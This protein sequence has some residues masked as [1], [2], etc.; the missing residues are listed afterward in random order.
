MAERPQPMSLRGTETILV[1]EDDSALRIVTCR[2]LARMGYTVI[3]A[4]DADAARNVA[5]AA[6]APIHLLLSDIVIPGTNGPE[7]AKELAQTH[8]DLKVL[9]MSG[10]AGDAAFRHGLLEEGVAFLPKPF[11]AE[12]LAQKV[13]AVLDA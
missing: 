5:T 2:L 12:T 3:H 6:A 11:T 7:L 13:R 10:Y 9:L 4:E 1:V 8:P